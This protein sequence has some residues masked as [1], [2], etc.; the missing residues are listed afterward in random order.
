MDRRRLQEN[1]R[2]LIACVDFRNGT[3]IDCVAST[4]SSTEDVTDATILG[5][6]KASDVV[7][8]N[9]TLIS[10]PTPNFLSRI[11][12][13]AMTTSLTRHEGKKE[14]MMEKA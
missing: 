12:G 13:V 8:T 2:F 6:E 9:V 5:L 4:S 1:S 11:L 14:I 7:L 10:N 3:F